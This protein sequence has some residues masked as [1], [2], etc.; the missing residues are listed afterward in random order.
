MKTNLIECRECFEKY[1]CAIEY[2]TGPG[3]RLR[4]GTCWPCGQAE[5]EDQRS[6]EEAECE[7]DEDQ[8]EE[9]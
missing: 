8:D 9:D 1:P 3:D 7:S 2:E 5:L 4:L 6:A